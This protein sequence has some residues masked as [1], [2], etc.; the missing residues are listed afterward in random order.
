MRIMLELS[1]HYE[2]D[3]VTVRNI[4]SR[5]EIS[6]KYIEQIIGLLNKAGLVRSQRGAAGGYRLAMAPEQITAGQVLRVTEGDIDVVECT[7]NNGSA[8][9][10]RLHECATSDIW[11]EI[12]SAV[13]GVVDN[14]TMADLVQN[15]QAKSCCNAV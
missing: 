10:S 8:P 1:L 6:E 13:E 3:L 5:Q 7:G 9:C 15:Y 11:K 12:K 2:K 14:I 4:A